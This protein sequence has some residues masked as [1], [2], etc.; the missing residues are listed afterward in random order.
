MNDAESTAKP[1]GDRFAADLRGFGPIGIVA[2]VVILA[3]QP[4][5][6]LSGI[7]VLGWVQLSRTPWAD[8]G[9][10][11]PRSWFADVAGGI[12]IGVALK[13]LLKAIVMPLLGADAVNHTYHFVVGNP[14]AAIA[15][16]LTFIVVGGFSEET[17]FRGFLFERFGKL[18]GKSIVAK[19]VTVLVTAMFFASLHFYDQGLAGAEQAIFTGLTFGTIYAATGRIWTVMC[20]HAAYDLAALAIIYWN[21]ESTFAHLV[22]K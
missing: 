15:E 8:I 4:L 3:G 7:L 20:A 1:S 22:F 5:A 17:V 2:I 16:M 21:L 10:V 19:S 12:V 9:Y 14:A 6:P 13:V 18:I 11:R